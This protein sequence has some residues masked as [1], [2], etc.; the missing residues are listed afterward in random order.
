MRKTA[1][2]LL[3]ALYV[4][5]SGL[6]LI[7]ASAQDNTPPLQL[8]DDMIDRLLTSYED[9]RELGD[10]YESRQA[11]NGNPVAGMAMALQ[12]RADAMAVAQRNGFADFGE[13]MD[14]MTTL[15]VT[16]AF[17]D[18]GQDYEQIEADR[19]KAM[20]Q[21]EAMPMDAAQKD[22]MRKMLMQSFAV[23][24][25]VTPENFALVKSRKDEIGA[26]MERN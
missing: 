14:A 13:W 26:A 2:T 3:I 25:K 12:G 15:G 9:M 23:I 21:I 1:K 5:V 4:C 10:K 20:A 19:K 8:T 11:P 17:V 7:P 6:F 22:A 18:S 16:Y 24:A